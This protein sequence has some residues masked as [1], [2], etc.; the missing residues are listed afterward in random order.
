MDPMG[1]YKESYVFGRL[2]S[3]VNFVDFFV[4]SRILFFWLGGGGKNNLGGDDLFSFKKIDTPIFA[5]LCHVDKH[6]GKSVSGRQVGEKNIGRVHTVDGRNPKQ[7]PGMYKTLQIMEYLPY[8]LVIAGFFFQSAVVLLK[9][10]CTSV[11]S[12]G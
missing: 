9:I 8:Q 7:P 3:C 10:G 11:T 5:R 12:V 1:I 4:A 2:T 6:R